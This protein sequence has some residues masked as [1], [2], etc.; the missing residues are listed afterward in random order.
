MGTAMGWGAS[1]ITSP[2]SWWR[3]ATKTAFS[4]V[5]VGSNQMFALEYSHF[6]WVM[7]PGEGCWAEQPP[8]ELLGGFTSVGFQHLVE[9]GMDKIAE[10]RIPCGVS[11]AEAQC[12]HENVRVKAAAKEAAELCSLQTVVSAWC[13]TSLCLWRSVRSPDQT[14]CVGCDQRRSCPSPRDTGSFFLLPAC[15]VGH[16]KGLW[17]RNTQLFFLHLHFPSF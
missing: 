13:P 17:P 1:N 14:Q 7:H 4:S 9:L 10:T 2:G 11:S 3:W 5:L 16:K 15:D 8:E 12:T 6:G